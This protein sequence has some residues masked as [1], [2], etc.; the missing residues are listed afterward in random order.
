MVKSRPWAFQGFHHGRVDFPAPSNLIL[1]ASPPHNV[2]P[3][4]VPAL[5]AT[6]PTTP[7]EYSENDP[8]SIHDDPVQP[9]SPHSTLSM[10]MNIDEEDLD[11]AASPPLDSSFVTFMRPA[12]LNS[13][14]FNHDSST[15]NMGRMPTPIYPNFHNGSMGGL[16]YPSSGMEG[17]ISMSNGH[18]GIPSNPIIQHARKQSTI[19]QDRGHRMPSPISEVEDI[20]DTP[21]A[22]TQSQLSRL[23]VTSSNHASEH[24]DVEEPSRDGEEEMPP[25]PPPVSTT[26]TRGRKRSGAFTGKGRFSMGYRDDCEKCRQRV[27]GHYSHF[28]S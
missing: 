28:L 3:H 16:E 6:T 8:A 12:K 14:L 13:N 21:I 19:D 2:P 9:P 25:P 4:N 26:P 23:S 11:M 24:M 27:P 1:G 15:N 22:L 18:L 5:E 7:S 20:P 10:E 17:G